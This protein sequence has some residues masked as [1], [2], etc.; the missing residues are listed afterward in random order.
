L[1]RFENV[2]LRYGMGP[3]VL[4]DVSFEIAADSFHFLTGPS[5][6]GKTTLL[7]LLFL[8]LKPTR[9]LVNVFGRDVSTLSGNDL[10]EMRRRI[11][12]VFQDFRLLDHLTTYENVALPLRVLGQEEARYR[13][14]VI[15][16]LHWVGLGERVHVLPPVLSG[17][18]KQRAAIARALIARP[19]LL[20]ADEPTGNVDPALARRLLRLFVELHRS[21]TSVVIATHDEALMDLV[22]ARRLRIEEGH[23]TVEEMPSWR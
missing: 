21:G 9:G 14:E 19:E 22:P 2:G 13:A 3:E 7:R 15:E 23:I 11:G 17:G 4:R 18:E 20:L 8:S 6:S 10:S 5:G 12:I 1:V 16:L